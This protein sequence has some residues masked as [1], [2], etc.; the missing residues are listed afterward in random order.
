MQVS[1]DKAEK[2]EHENRLKE[3]FHLQ[4]SAKET[5]SEAALQSVNSAYKD[6][7]ASIHTAL[8]LKTTIPEE[9]V[10]FK[11]P[12]SFNLQEMFDKWYLSPPSSPVFADMAHDGSNPEDFRKAWVRA[13]KMLKLSK[14]ELELSGR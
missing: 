10:V 12:Q 8:G 1:P 3:K 4:G 13:Q 9:G 11:V 2:K 7:W 5:I 6:Y 14:V